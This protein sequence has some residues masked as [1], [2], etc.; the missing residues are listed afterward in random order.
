MS[1]SSTMVKRQLSATELIILSVLLSILMANFGVFFL[2]KKAQVS[3]RVFAHLSTHFFSKITLVRSKWM[4]DNKPDWVNLISTTDTTDK[5]IRSTEYIPVNKQG[6]IDITVDQADCYTIWQYALGIPI[7]FMQEPVIVV[8]L[9]NN[10]ETA[11]A[12]RTC[13]YSLNS[14]INFEY[15]P[16]LG[17]IV[18]NTLADNR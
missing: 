6:W 12:G 4:L 17:K 5:G 18:L 11:G 13:R 2:S 8:K 7:A 15:T 16:S 3:D 10:F 1:I 14:G 9:D